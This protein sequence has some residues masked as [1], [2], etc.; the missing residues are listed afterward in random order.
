MLQKVRSQ[1]VPNPIGNIVGVLFEAV[2]KFLT[3]L[4]G[5]RITLR[6]NA[7]RQFCIQSLPSRRDRG[8]M[9]D[10]GIGVRSFGSNRHGSV[11]L[12]G[13]NI[14]VLLEVLANLLETLPQFVACDPERIRRVAFV[15]ELHLRNSGLV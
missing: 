13:V 9:D 15:I 6:V 12:P 8:T 10:R 11:I 7:V 1:I 5:R 4:T 14:E 2:F 3:I